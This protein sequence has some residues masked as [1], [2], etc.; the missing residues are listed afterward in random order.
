MVYNATSYNVV[1]IWEKQQQQQHLFFKGLFIFIYLNTLLL[2][3]DTPE[4][5]IRFH[6]RESPC[7]C[8]ELNSGPLEEQPLLLT[9]EPSWQPERHFLYKVS[10]SPAD[11]VSTEILSCSCTWELGAHQMSLFVWTRSLGY[12]CSQKG[13]RNSSFPVFSHVCCE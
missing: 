9:A 13:F 12:S 4:K 1:F 2:S 3:S 11:M 6:Y 7:G 8:W 10:F 5:G